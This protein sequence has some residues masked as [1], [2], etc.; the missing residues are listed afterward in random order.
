MEYLIIITIFLI[1]LLLGLPVS[2]TMIVIGSFVLMINMGVEIASLQIPQVIYNSF[3]SSLLV[4]IPSFIL[5]GQVII[6]SG[7]GAL[8]FSAADKWFGHLPGGLAIATIICCAFF[9][10][11]S[12]SSLA[13]LLTFGYLAS[14]EMIRIGYPKKFAYGLLAGTGTLGILIPPSTPMI[15]YSA[16]TSQSAS[17]LFIGA[18]I[19]SLIIILLFLM[20]V[21]FYARKLPRKEKVSMAERLKS[22]RE[23]IWIFLIPI[24]IVG[25][26]YSGF[27]TVTEAAGVSCV[28]SIILAVFVYKTVKWKEM[29]EV[30]KAAATNSGMICLILGG[31]MLFG[32]AITLI[33]LP[34]V[35]QTFFQSINLNKWSF[36]LVLSLLLIVLGM[37]MEVV[38]ILMIITP[39]MYPI[40]L[41]YGFDLVWFGIYLVILL[42]VAV[43]TP[44][45]GMNLFIMLQVSEKH[46]NKF[47]ILKMSKA[48][49]PYVLL[50]LFLVLLIVMIPGLVTWLPSIIDS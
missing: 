48:T 50:M 42:E 23:I 29:I 30:L 20:Y 27:F 17:D 41:S 37:F 32:F 11:L 1:L 47:D 25:G 40:M 24:I 38:S 7:I 49:I 22:L 16:M 14:E 8:A 4:A 33:E 36:L 46:G 6:K 19:P 2:F 26:I 44:P 34:Q 31:A 3:N 5:A 28:V 9:S 12:G 15:L 18:T 10:S 21:I 39:I 45:V 13:T 35:I 43:I